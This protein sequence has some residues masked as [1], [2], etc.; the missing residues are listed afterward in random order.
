MILLVSFIFFKNLLD[1]QTFYNVNKWIE[2]AKL[3]R[4]SDLL[5]ILVGNKIDAAEKRQVATEE[6]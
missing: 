4:G 2:D 1:K 3:I 6:G 5:I